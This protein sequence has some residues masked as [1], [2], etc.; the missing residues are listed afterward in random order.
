MGV[1]TD[2]DVYPYGPNRFLARGDFASQ[3][4][5]LAAMLGVPGP[6]EIRVL[7][8][9]HSQSYRNKLSRGHACEMDTHSRN[10]LNDFIVAHDVAVLLCG[11]VHD[12]P[13]VQSF[14]ANHLKRSVEFLEAR[15][16]TTTQLSTLPHTWRTILGR[17]PRRPK[18]W[19]N[20][21]LVHRLNQD[22]GEIYWNTEIYL[23]KPQGFYNPA[24]LL[25]GVLVTPRMRVWP[26]A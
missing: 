9:H 15:C 16:G 14:T 7:C 23:E 22:G 1:D 12:P 21:L 18:R 5:D 6:N 4:R 19:P 26:R 10:S 8:L 20:S 13:L 11:H 2:A 3:L 17:R 25:P 24:A